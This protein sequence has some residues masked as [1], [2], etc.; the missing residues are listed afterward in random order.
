MF[1]RLSFISVRMLRHYAARGLLVPAEVDDATGYR[2]YRPGQLAEARQVTAL[3]DAGFGIEDIA[4]VLAVRDDPASVSTLVARQRQRLLA[5]RDALEHRLAALDR[6]RIEAQ[7]PV[8]T[9]A[10]L[11]AMTVLALRRVIARHADEGLLWE[12]LMPLA[13]PHLRP[14]ARCG[15]TFHDEQFTAEDPD[16]EVWAEVPGPVPVTAPVRCERVPARRVVTATLHG[17]FDRMGEVTSAIGAYLGER[18]LDAGPMFTVYRVG[19][20]QDPDPENW[21]TEVCFTV[22]DPSPDTTTARIRAGSGPS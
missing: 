9:E 19:P 18:G 22:P 2:F 6:L 1:S 15:A 8:V 21:V 13:A 17:P 20:A 3:R 7:A 11:P 14:E 10:V 16:V 12:H 5:E 4:A